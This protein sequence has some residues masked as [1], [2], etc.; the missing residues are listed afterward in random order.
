MDMVRRMSQ[1]LLANTYMKMWDAFG[2]SEFTLSDI[3][4]RLDIKKSYARNLLSQLTSRGYVSSR[5]DNADKRRRLYRLRVKAFDDVLASK[6]LLARG[7]FELLKLFGSYR[8]EYVAIVDGKVVD[9]DE[10]LQALGKRVLG[11]YPLKS[12]YVTCIGTPRKIGILE[13]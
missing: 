3:V 10:D 6:E 1:S 5:A 8:G 9:H 7:E 13:L 4:S 11:E 2:V 12:L